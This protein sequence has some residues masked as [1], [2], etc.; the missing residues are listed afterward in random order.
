MFGDS[1][2]LFFFFGKTSSLPPTRKTTLDAQPPQTLARVFIF[3]FERYRSA[4]PGIGCRLEGGRIPGIGSGGSLGSFSILLLF[5]HRCT[6]HQ[7]KQEHD[8]HW[9][10][11]KDHLWR[12]NVRTS[13]AR[14][15]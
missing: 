2:G 10:E 3:Y 6:C 9:H 12:P 8:Q 13:L 15:I 7:H 11:P 5:G 14:T 1:A 4:M